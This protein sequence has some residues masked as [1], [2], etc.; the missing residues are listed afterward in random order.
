MC[1]FIWEFA[2]V[3]YSII[4]GFWYP[5]VLDLVT[6]VPLELFSLAVEDSA[7][8]MDTSELKSGGT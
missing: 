6:A 1:C 5:V 2:T 8:V 4:Y 7:Y 3:Y